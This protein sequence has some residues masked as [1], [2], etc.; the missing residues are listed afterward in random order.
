MWCATPAATIETRFLFT[1]PYLQHRVPFPFRHGDG[2]LSPVRAFGL[3]PQDDS[4]FAS[5]RR[6]AQLLWDNG[7]R[8]EGNFEFAVD[9]CSDCAGRQLVVAVIDRPPSLAA[10]IERFAVSTPRPLD[11][12]AVLLVPEL[13]GYVDGIELRIGRGGDHVTGSAADRVGRATRHLLVDR[14]FLLIKRRRDTGTPTFAMWIEDA[15]LL[16]PFDETQLPNEPP[17]A[18]RYRM[19]EVHD[20][21]AIKRL[22]GRVFHFTRDWGAQWREHL[23]REE[24]LHCDLYIECKQASEEL[25]RD[26]VCERVHLE[27]GMGGPLLRVLPSGETWERALRQSEITLGGPSPDVRL[28]AIRREPRP[29]L[30]LACTYAQHPIERRD[31]GMHLAAFR[32]DSCTPDEITTSDLREDAFFVCV[33]GT[34]SQHAALPNALAVASWRTIGKV[35]A[36]YASGVSSVLVPAGTLPGFGVDGAILRLDKRSPDWTDILASGTLAMYLRTSTAR[37]TSLALIAQK[38]SWDD[39]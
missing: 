39:F 17:P 18:D 13:A 27:H 25:L 5:L 20:D 9:L 30:Q 8:S 37:D 1:E 31:N 32:Q 21:V 4:R 36:G 7:S 33:T 22:E 15:A 12:H 23:T 3:R 11:A 10:A 29:P 26:L 34:T 14:P 6:Q 2:S 24:L 19:V 38:I 35:L 28:I 16:R